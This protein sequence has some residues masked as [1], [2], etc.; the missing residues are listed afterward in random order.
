M[1]IGAI[2]FKGPAVTAAMQNATTLGVTID[3]PALTGLAGL[4]TVT[5]STTAVL[6]D[7]GKCVEV[8]S[9]SAQTFT[10]PPNSSVA[11]PVGTVVEVCRLGTGTVTV[12]P[13]SGVTIRNPLST[14]ALRAQ[15]SSAALRKRATDEWVVSGDLG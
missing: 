7:A 6:A 9:S 2:N 10:V 12:T 8:N 5:S 1:A 11:F 15:Y 14:L 4:R 13:G 3:H